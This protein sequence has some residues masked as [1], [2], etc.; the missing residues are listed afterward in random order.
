MPK[1]KVINPNFTKVTIGFASPKEILERSYGEVKEPLTQNYRTYKAEEKGLCCPRIFGPEESWKCSCGKL[2]GIRYRNNI[3][4]R[5]GVEIT[6]KKARRERMGHIKLVVPVVNPLCFRYPPYPI[7]KLLNL[8]NKELKGIIYYSSYVVIQPGIKKKSGMQRMDLLTI[9]DYYKLLETIP[10]NELLADSDPNKFI[11]KTGAIAIKVLLRELDL[12]ALAENLRN[13][14]KQTASQQKRADIIKRLHVVEGFLRPEHGTENRP[15]WMVME[16]IPVIPPD[17]RPVFELNNGRFATSDITEKQKELIIRNNRLARLIAIGAPKVIKDNEARMVQG[18]VDSSLD[19]PPRTSISIASDRPLKSLVDEL[20][21]KQGLFRQNLLGKRVDFSAR[22]VI[23]VGPALKM[24][25]CGLPKEMALKLFRSFVISKLKQRGIVKTFQEGK[26]MVEERLP[27]VWDVLANVVTGHPVLLN[28]APTLHRLG[29]QALLPRLV[30]GKSIQLHPLL[31]TAF[32]ADFDGDHMAVHVPLSQEAIAEAHMLLRPSKNIFNPANGEPIML[33]SKDM[34]LGMYFLTKEADPAIAQQLKGA[35]KAFTSRAEVILAFNTGKLDKH[36]PIK[37]QIKGEQGALE[38]IETTPG[39][40]LFNQAV[41]EEVGY[42]NMLVGGKQIG[43]IVKQVFA[44][45]GAERT[46]IFLDDIKALGFHHIYEGGLTYGLDDMIAP[47]DKDK[48]IEKGEAEVMHIQENYHQGFITDTERYNQTIDAWTKV[49]NKITRSVL[50]RLKE[51]KGGYN[52]LWMMKD[53]GARGSEDQLKQVCGMRGLM[54]KIQGNAHSKGNIVERPILSSLLS[55]MHLLEYFLSASASRKSLADSTLKTA[56]AGFFGRQLTSV[57]QSV[58]IAIA[59]CR[60]LAGRIVK[61]IY[62]NGQL[63]VTIGEQVEGRIVLENVVDPIS[64]QVICK[65]N[66]LITLTLA[67]AIDKSKILSLKV[68]SP[69]YCESTRGICASC[70]G[71]NLGT[72]R[73]AIIGD[74]VG[75]LAAHSISE[76]GTQL[77]LRSFHSGGSAAVG[78][79]QEGKAVAIEAGEVRLS[80]FKAV[81]TKDKQIVINRNSELTLIDKKTKQEI[82]RHVLPYSA[83]LF[84]KD[85]DQVKKGDALFEY[86]PYTIPILAHVS[87]KVN[88]EAMEEGVNYEESYN[89]QTGHKEKI[90]IDTQD[91]QKVPS[92]VIKDKE[93]NLTHYTIPPKARIVVDENEEITPGSILAKRPRPRSTPKDIVGGLPQVTKL[94]QMQ[95]VSSKGVKAGI[96]GYVKIGNKK[97]SKIEI[98][99]EGDSGVTKTYG[100]PVLQ[101]LLVQDGDYVNA[102]DLLSDGRV[103]PAD[104]LTIKG[105]NNFINYAIQ[106]VQSVYQLQGIRIDDKHLEVILRQM[107]QKV[108]IV[109][110]GDTTFIPTQQ[111]TKHIFLAANEKLKDKRLILDPGDTPFK[112][113]SLVSLNRILLENGSLRS[114]KLQEA[115]YRLPEPAIAKV[116]AKGISASALASDSFIAAAS[117][118]ETV[119]SLLKAAV[120]GKVD[121]LEGLKEAAI[122]G[123][124]CPA[125]TGLVSYKD[126][127]VNVKREE[128][129]QKE[130]V[131][132]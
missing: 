127:R 48:I 46:A 118:Q 23:T 86:D 125:G 79:V 74:A 77:T 99:I 66:S 57:A 90:I 110:V 53:S 106:E 41:P 97:R 10:D 111:V 33:P 124:L 121:K 120:K 122:V 6:D 65:R 50:K 3:C 100:V 88:L 94:L 28:R 42:I 115:T 87:G 26:K 30:E 83:F 102:G 98:I 14:F 8:S 5:C 45:V 21:G 13:D 56:D 24:D 116:I 18:T 107:T 64:K 36:A 39:R 81:A 130:V 59:D 129:E 31:C 60:T 123:K 75:N 40:V 1:V 61:A 69:I 55:G 12:A 108:E 49:S 9:K 15:E 58:V 25:E 35:G 63:S 131:A 109:S 126:L 47:P 7:A 67:Q 4:D 101:Q 62:A 71:L 16:Y 20:K 95:N 34:V 119:K 43:S 92:I 22:S 132:I 113:R 84:V 29:I 85:G 72:K 19:R 104:I 70:Y 11:A 128:A 114:Q 93:G 82:Q 27:I 38:I 68:R 54:S 52:T 117:F 91:K 51:D 96:D 105:L 73:K 2:Q 37:L 89:Q 103:D 76:P 44:K 78:M 112:K 32:N 17:F 80:N